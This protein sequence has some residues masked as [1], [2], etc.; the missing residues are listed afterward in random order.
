MSSSAGETYLD[1]LFEASPIGMAVFDSSLRYVRI[2]R[3]LAEMNGVAVAE[4]I[5]R[6]TREVIPELAPTVDPILRRALASSEGVHRI[7]VSGETRAQPGVERHWIASWL[8]IE[9]R[10]RKSVV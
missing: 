6:T 5:G 8:P 2:N 3:A 10:D 9:V 4:H 1:A 7:P